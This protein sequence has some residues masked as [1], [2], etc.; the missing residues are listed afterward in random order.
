MAG[1]SMNDMTSKAFNFK[2]ALI[3]AFKLFLELFLISTISLVQ[4]VYRQ[5]TKKHHFII[6]V[7][8]ISPPGIFTLKLSESGRLPLSLI[9]QL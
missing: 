4:K 1:S 8:L 5:V 3:H 7:H 9:R 2:I 6:T